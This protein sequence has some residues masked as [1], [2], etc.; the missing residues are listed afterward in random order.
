MELQNCPSVKPHNQVNLCVCMGQIWGRVESVHT[1][2]SSSVYEHSWGWRVM[3]SGLEMTGEMDR[4]IKNSTIIPEWK[5]NPH[6]REKK[7][8]RH[9]LGQRVEVPRYLMK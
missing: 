4:P 3:C 5:V 2:N 1:C 9:I 7:G 8:W 6:Q